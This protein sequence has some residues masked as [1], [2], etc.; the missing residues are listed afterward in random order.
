MKGCEVEGRTN[1]QTCRIQNAQEVVIYLAGSKTD[2]YNQGT[3]RN[4]YRSGDPILCPVRA[5]GEMERYY[6]ER[7]RGAEAEEPLFRFEDGVPIARDDIHGLV[8]LSAVADGQEGARFG[9]HSLRI[10][11][12][13][14]STKDLEQVKRYGRWTSDAFHDYLWENHERQ[15]GLSTKMA[16]AD[17]QLLAP[18]KD[19]LGVKVGCMRSPQEEDQPRI[20]AHD[21]NPS[22]PRTTHQELRIRRPLTSR[23]GNRQKTRYQQ[24][25]QPENRS[26]PTRGYSQD[27]AASNSRCSHNKN[28]GGNVGFGGGVGEKG[29]T[30]DKPILPSD[31]KVA[32]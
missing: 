30:T 2:Q 3:I 13:Y 10:A 16:R 25:N 24:G 1:N 23:D 28:H 27:T 9:S 7:F 18:R 17:G 31:K 32:S 22:A 12:L 15:R 29:A 5:L 19:E 14:Q 26:N 8:Q 11:A 6:P 21:L 4:H 20:Q